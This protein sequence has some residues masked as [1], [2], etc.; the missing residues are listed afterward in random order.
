MVIYTDPVTYTETIFFINYNIYSVKIKLDADFLAGVSG[1]ELDEKGYF[2]IEGTD[3][4]KVTKEG[5]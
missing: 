4:V 1:L 2:V 5:R 3:Y